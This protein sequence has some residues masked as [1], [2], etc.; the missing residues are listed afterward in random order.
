LDR[1]PLLCSWQAVNA[2]IQSGTPVSE[3]ASVKQKGS[4][5]CALPID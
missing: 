3:F 5:I 1:S 4:A 2:R